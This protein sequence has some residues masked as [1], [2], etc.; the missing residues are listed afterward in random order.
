MPESASKTTRDMQGAGGAE[1]TD[2]AI[3]ARGLVRKFGAFTA[4]N[5]VSFTVDGHE[6]SWQKS[7][8]RVGFSRRAGASAS[9]IGREE[10]ER[11]VLVALDLHRA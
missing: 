7:L 2:P 6:A 1:G 5:G 4:V 9:E 8:F 10:W 3:S 11:A